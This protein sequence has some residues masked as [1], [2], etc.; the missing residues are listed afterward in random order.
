MA[1]PAVELLVLRGVGVLHADDDAQAFGEPHLGIAPPELLEKLQGVR[2]EVVGLGRRQ[3]EIR[4]AQPAFGQHGQA[5]GAIDQDEVV[6]L[7]CLGQEGAN[8][9]PQ[10]GLLPALRNLALEQ[11]QMPAAQH[12]VDRARIVHVGNAGDDERAPV[13]GL[14]LQDEGDEIVDK[15]PALALDGRQPLRGDQHRADAGVRIGIDDQHPLGMM[16]GQRL[17]QREHEARLADAALGVHDGY[18]IAH[19]EPRAPIA[20]RTPAPPGHTMAQPRIICGRGPAK[21]TLAKNA[22][23]TPDRRIKL[24]LRPQTALDLHAQECRSC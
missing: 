22:S 24:R 9:Q 8:G 16:G 1:Q 13:R 20:A 18:G 23:P 12:Q 3:A 14:R 4:L 2:G 5:G 19:A 11:R 10:Q 6:G 17:G 7:A 15:G 21:A